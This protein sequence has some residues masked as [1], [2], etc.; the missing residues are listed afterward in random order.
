MN[1]FVYTFRIV[2]GGTVLAEDSSTASQTRACNH[3]YQSFI[4]DYPLGTY[5][6]Q[7]IVDNL[8]N[9][10][11]GSAAGTLTVIN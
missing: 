3:L 11:S 2:Q 8:T 6:V 10:V 9:Q 4:D 7:V 5:E 1:D